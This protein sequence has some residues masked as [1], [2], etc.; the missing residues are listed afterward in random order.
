M[1]LDFATISLLSSA[2]ERVCLKIIIASVYTFIASTRAFQKFSALTLKTRATKGC[3]RHV[4]AAHDVSAFTSI[5]SHLHPFLRNI[6]HHLGSRAAWIRDNDGMA[7]SEDVEDYVRADRRGHA[8]GHVGIHPTDRLKKLAV[9]SAAAA[10]VVGVG[11]VAKED[12]LERVAAVSGT[13]RNKSE[14][15]GGLLHEIGIVAPRGG[16]RQVAP[17]RS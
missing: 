2:F 16:K 10:K 9:D 4:T 7:G 5:S 14:A 17:E 12:R 8:L 15:G 11:V 1:Y 6:L 13:L 3:G